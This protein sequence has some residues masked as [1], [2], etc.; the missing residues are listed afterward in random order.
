MAVIL[1]T[2]YGKIGH[3]SEG[4]V[5]SRIGATLSSVNSNTGTLAGNGDRVVSPIQEDDSQV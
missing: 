1:Q 2:R 4:F 3:I 5:L